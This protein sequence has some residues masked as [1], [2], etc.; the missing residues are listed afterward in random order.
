MA[1]TR[2]DKIAGIHLDSVKHN[3]DMTNGLFVQ[4]GALETGET[5]LYAVKQATVDAD[6]LDEFLLHATPEVMADPRKSGL[7]DFVVTSGTAGRAYHLVK[8]D[9]ITLTDDLI[10]GTTVVGQFAVPQLASFKLEA[11]ADGT[12]LKQDGTTPVEPS[13]V[14]QVI[15]KTTL[16]YDNSNAT[17]LRV[18]KA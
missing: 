4:L 10:D 6:L 13:L 14:L 2:L 9:I 16:G 12:T 8:G 5:E 1:V 15:Q 18:I 3:A 17:V 11:S 7:K